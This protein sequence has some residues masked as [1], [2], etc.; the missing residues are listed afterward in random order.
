MCRHILLFS[1][2]ITIGFNAHSQIDAVVSTAAFTTP[3]ESPYLE[4]YTFV[5]GKSLKNDFTEDS[6]LQS[7]VDVLL[8]IKKEEKIV[9]FDKYRLNS[10]AGERPL[11]FIDLKRFS[12][13]N[14]AYLLEMEFVDSKDTSNYLTVQKNIKIDFHT[15]KVIVSDIELLSSTNK[16]EEGAESIFAKDGVEMVPLVHDYYN[17][18]I[19]TLQF[20][21]ELYNTDKHIGEDYILSYSLKKIA[22]KTEQLVAIVHKRKSPEAI[23]PVLLV[24][25]IREVPSGQYKL[26]VEVKD[27]NEGLIASR[28]TSFYRSNPYLDQELKY[29]DTDITHEFVAD[30][31][32]LQLEYSL[33]AIGPIV[34]GPDQEMINYMVKDKNEN[35][36]RMFLFAYWAKEDAI[37]PQI[38]YQQYMAVAKAVDK[39]FRSGFRYG[40]ET[41][42]GRVFL[43]YGRP[44]DIVQRETEQSAP[45]YEIW[46]YNHLPETKQNNVKFI[47]YNPSLAGDDYVLLH[48]DARGEYNNPNW[49]RQLY[50]EAPTQ[51]QGSNYFDGTGVQDNMNRNAARLYDDF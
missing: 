40:F 12:L 8:L 36:Q 3:A 14:G 43:K 28:E 23:T 21:C 41:D 5:N 51:I 29:K 39:Q 46:S 16:L 49:E 22:N 4:V 45:P 10:P 18:K 15:D 50:G 20:Y 19:G 27:R 44:N 33:R 34:S 9:R 37:Q 35:A 7:A 48:S 13:E 25:D 32:P 47:F 1:F 42:R 6:L 31:T 11:N 30:L 26:L 2:F 38:A 17:R 24:L